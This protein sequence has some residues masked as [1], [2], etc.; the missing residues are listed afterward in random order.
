MYIFFKFRPPTG[1]WQMLVKYQ[2]VHTTY[3][4]LASNIYLFCLSNSIHVVKND[5]A[6][7]TSI[8][9][10][11]T[12]FSRC[13][14]YLNRGAAITKNLGGPDSWKSASKNI[15]SNT[16]ITAKMGKIG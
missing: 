3:E 10:K 7:M 9:P 5:E 15:L 1:N 16:C 2:L 11:S 4:V 14:L 12:D 13:K 6:N 8:Q